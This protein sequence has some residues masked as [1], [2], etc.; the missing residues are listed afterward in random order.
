MTENE[1]EPPIVLT[2]ALQA[3]FD[4][5]TSS[6]LEPQIT[7]MEGDDNIPDEAY[8]RLEFPNG[9]GFRRIAISDD[10]ANEL[11][12]TAA[13]AP[14]P[15]AAPHAPTAARGACGPP[16][17]SRE[18][19][20]AYT[21]AG[22]IENKFIFRV[23]QQE[24]TNLRERLNLPPAHIPIARKL[25]K[26]EFLAYVGDFGYVVDCFAT[27]TA[28]ERELFNTDEAIDQKRPEVDDFDLDLLEHLWPATVETGLQAW[29]TAATKE[30]P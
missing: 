20:L 7:I 28:Q 1:P 22:E 30:H 29:L 15:P 21:I 4:R 2:D 25:R 10:Q 14:A 5:A 24:E 16:E 23:N 6:G 12:S 13:D 26:G 19:S 9:R 17:G 3:N 8:L 11:V 27:S 18:R